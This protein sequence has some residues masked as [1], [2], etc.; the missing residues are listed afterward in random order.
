MTVT[1]MALTL[2]AAPAQAAADPTRLAPQL[3]REVGVQGANRHLV[4]FQ[5]IADTSGGTRAASRTGHQRSSQYV[6]DTL[7][8]AGYRVSFQDLPFTYE[9]TLAQSGSEISPTPRTLNPHVMGGSPTT[10]LGGMTA[11]LAV[12][13][14]DDS[15]GCEPG[16]FADGRYDGKIALVKR[17]S[18]AFLTKQLNAAA[19]G[20]DGLLVYNNSPEPDE[21]SAGP[22]GVGASTVVPTAGLTRAEGEALTADAAAATVTLA[23]ELR[24]LTE[25]RTTRN[26]IAETTDG[27]ADN[28]VM[29]GAHLDSVVAGP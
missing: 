5:R 23:L 16:D 20:A 8:A 14:V 9:E 15:P 4:A 21:V 24:A 1:A 27:R 17:G 7:A 12:V 6:Y 10:P 2:S 25:R 29:L 18:C 28:T 11:A 3:V 13:P 26:V 19:A 22:L